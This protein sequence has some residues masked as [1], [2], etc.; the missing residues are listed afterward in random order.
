[1]PYKDKEKRIQY[2]KEYRLKNKDNLKEKR[3]IYVEKNK[4][5][6]KEKAKI[7]NKKN[8]DNLKEK[9]K[10]YW[11]ENKDDI[12]SKQR[13]KYSE[14][15][16][17]ISKQRKD[18]RRKNGDKI[19]AA[20]REYKKKNKSKFKIKAEKFYKKNREKILKHKKKYYQ[21]NI[22]KILTYKEKY[23]K[24]YRENHMD[25]ICAW[26]WN[27]SVTKFCSPECWKHYNHGERSPLWNGGPKLYPDIWNEKFRKAIRDRDNNICMRC[28]KPREILNRALAVHHIDGN[29]W[30][31]CVENCIS[32][33]NSCH[34]IVGKSDKKIETFKP[35]FENMLNKLYGYKYE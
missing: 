25:N 19:R 7:Y 28:R 1:M 34:T 3:E 9:R 35:L 20:D 30:N 31:T 14:N 12:N 33:C 4:K 16:H 15:K 27:P 2:L 10:I 13:K 29:P 5:S 23:R 22:E 26:C 11:E 6:I 24:K 32:L 21:E 8:K 18:N 17:K